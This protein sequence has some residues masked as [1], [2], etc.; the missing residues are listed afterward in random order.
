M[1]FKAI[2]FVMAAMLMTSCFDNSYGGAPVDEGLPQKLVF[3]HT[4]DTHG[5]YLPFWMEPNMFDR[6]MG[7]Q[8]SNPPC[9]DLDYSGGGSYCNG[10]YNSATGKYQVYENNK[11]VYYTKEELIEKGYYAEGSIEKGLVI[12]DINEDGRCDILDCQRCW[13]TNNNNICDPEEDLDYD[14]VE[15]TGRG[16]SSGDCWDPYSTAHLTC[17]DKNNNG[18]CDKNEDINFDGWCDTYDCAL[19]YD[20]NFNGKCDYPYD[21]QKRTWRDNNGKLILRKDYES[22][23]AYNQAMVKAEKESEDINR[24]G[25]CDYSDYRPGL[26]NTG[27]IARAKTLI[28]EIR[29]KH[30][31]DGIPVLY[32]DSGDT[33]QGAPEFNLYKGDVEMLSMQKLGVDAMVIGNHEFDNGTGGL[34]AA[35]KKSGGFPML[36]SNYL[37]DPDGHKGLMDISSPYLIVMTGGLTVGIVG[38]AND[39]SINSGYQIG[40]STGFNFLD[41]IETTQTYVNSLRPLVDI[42]V[43]LSHQ[44][45]DGDY[46]I[47]ENVK[48]VD[49]ILGGHHHVVLDPPKVLQGPDGRDVI[50]IH[51]GVNLKVIGELEIA[52]QN[53][54]IVWHKYAT[55]AITEKIAE[56]GDFVNMLK[57]YVQG[58]DYSQY[59]QKKVGYA[60]STIVRN[61]PAN[62]DSPLGN[63]VTDA[64]MNHELAK[65]QL[66]VTNSMGIRADIP[67]GDITLEKLYEVFPFENSITTMY[68]SGNELKTL[69]DFVAR[70][71]ATRGCKTQVQVA[72]IGVEL[73]C[74]PPEELQKKHNSYALTKCLQIGNTL[75][76]DNYEVLLPNLL[77]KMATNDYMG[78]GGSGFYMLEANTTRLDTS[79]S[80]RDAVIDFFDQTGELNPISWSQNQTKPDECGR[81]K[82]ILMLN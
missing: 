18:E 77:F 22:D 16:C 58:L 53:K 64:M 75:V 33:F 51:S 4:T 20:R 10:I 80:L 71:S 45:L 60:T 30:E 5:K 21:S 78:R 9:W 32:L 29:A 76:I 52:V 82:R 74:N 12:E 67:T 50:I 43:V 73:D 34:V 24:D 62:G 37:F 35:Y 48:G 26:I 49:L 19:V 1:K 15:Q 61:D 17:W 11:Y 36:A 38:V 23:S 27:G 66:C 31:R 55:H 59:L 44:G 7:L 28:D 81:G 25:K 79:V 8:S 13:D 63:I 56:N 57:P 70:K 40:G 69:F 14:P 47:A 46:K 54:R 72:G 68:L 41:P 3:I 39:S 6:N 65:A 42:V 2:L